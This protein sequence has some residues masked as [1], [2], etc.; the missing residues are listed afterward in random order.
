M[1]DEVPIAIYPIPGFSEPVSCFTHLIGAGV[2]LVL[3]IVLL[4]R[5]RGHRGRMIALGV[6]AFACV[7]LLSISGTYHMLS[8]GS[9]GREVLRR[10]DHA[11]IFTLI[12]GSFTAVHALL[13][14]G[15]WRWGMIA[16]IWT[17]AITAITFKTLF[18]HGVPE[19]LSLAMYLGMGWIGLLSGVKLHRRFGFRFVRPLLWGALAYTFGAVLE[20]LR[21]PVPI[22]GVVGPHELFHLAVLAGVF[23]HWRFIHSFTDRSPILRCQAPTRLPIHNL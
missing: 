22:P 4:R 8:P 13:F 6:F 10:L 2:F 17:L 1:N 18:F 15:P 9:A 21:W 5:G 23:F 7:F 19:W 16:A 14:R 12:A 11:A 20:Y 3:G